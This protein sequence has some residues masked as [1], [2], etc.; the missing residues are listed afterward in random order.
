M[1]PFPGSGRSSRTVAAGRRRGA[2]LR[3]AAFALAAVVA[4][5]SA[6]ADSSDVSAA[7]GASGA[8]GAAASAVTSAAPIALT[9]YALDALGRSLEGVEIRLHSTEPSTGRLTLI[10]AQTDTSGKF[11]FADLAP[12]SYRVIAV[13]GGYAVLVGQVNTLFQ[14]TMELVLRPAGDEARPGTRPAD[15]SWVLRLPRRDP[16]EDRGPAVYEAAGYEPEPAGASLALPMTLELLA[17]STADSTHGSETPG[18]GLAAEI[19][20]SFELE[21]VGFVGLSYRHENAGEHERSLDRADVL[22]ARFAPHPGSGAFPVELSLDAMRGR[23]DRADGAAGLPL[24][25]LSEGASLQ[26]RWTG[27]GSEG[28]VSASLHAAMFRAEQSGFSSAGLSVDPDLDQDDA[29]LVALEVRGQRS[30]GEGRETTYVA[31]LR[32]V[33]GGSTNDGARGAEL[34]LMPLIA[35]IESAVLDGLDAQSAGFTVENRWLAERLGASMNS[36]VRVEHVGGIGDDLRA[37]MSVG[38]RW[39]LP[40]GLALEVDGGAALDTRGDVLPLFIASLGGETERFLWAVS[41]R[42]ETGVAPWR[43]T[44]ADVRADGFLPV[45]TDR[46]GDLRGV[47]A[48]ASYRHGENWPE[49]KLMV[50]RFFVEGR[51]AAD[52]PGD[53]PWV[54]IDSE[55]DGAGVL[56]D[57]FVDSPGTGTSLGLGWSEVEDRGDAGVLLSGAER[58]TWQ[59]LTLRQRLGPEGPGLR[60]QLVVG[61]ERGRAVDT[62]ERGAEAARLALLSQSRVSGGLALAF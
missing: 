46:D 7:A 43:A 23:R 59:Q 22:Q 17:S 18:L 13:K 62:N 15:G 11:R 12:G 55:G 16:L 45:M 6:D 25:V 60:W 28:T 29:D 39:R 44:L 50:E 47:S 30:W 20:S 24:H 58:W 35:E 42:R 31:S 2:T 3:I 1:S 56:V 4:P 36:R 54:P 32:S 52:L 48:S 53:L 9:G 51:L 14:N 21:D 5:A 38:G 49:L 33:S 61:V 34:A 10:T 8:T 27:T 19:T 26:A 40:A 37:S 41:G 57:L